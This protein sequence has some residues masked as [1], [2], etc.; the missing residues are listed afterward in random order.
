MSS[1]CGSRRLI[2]DD[3]AAR[4]FDVLVEADTV[5]GGVVRLRP[6]VRRAR[7]TAAS[8]ASPSRSATTR[9]GCTWPAPGARPSAWRVRLRL[10]HDVLDLVEAAAG[11]CAATSEAAS[12]HADHV[13][14]RPDLPP[15]RAA[16]DV[17]PLPALLRRPG[18]SATSTACSPRST[19]STGSP[20]GVGSANGGR[21]R[22]D[23]SRA[24]QLLGFDRVLEHTRDAMWQTDGLVAAVS[25]GDEPGRDAE[26]ARR[27]SRDLGER[28]VRLGRARRTATRAAA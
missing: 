5:P 20:A 25:R 17:R 8:D 1:C 2:P 22:Y 12:R 18:R 11:F 26:Q 10:R 28:R 27:G 16:L 13:P 19:C 3:A 7:T 9:G 4:L 23:R 24:A 6:G 15:A 21:L 14:R